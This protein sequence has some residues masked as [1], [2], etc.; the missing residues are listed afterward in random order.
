MTINWRKPVIGTLAAIITAITPTI[1]TFYH[2]HKFSVSGVYHIS[3][4]DDNW[5]IEYN[6]RRHLA[7][8]E[9]ARLHRGTTI[10]SYNREDPRYV[11]FMCLRGGDIIHE[12]QLGLTSPANW[13]A[14]KL[15]GMP[16]KE[17][18]FSITIDL[19]SIENRLF[20]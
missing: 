6:V 17:L 16:Q 5:A 4:P 14:E 8:N 2:N 19:S 9:S 15:L 20:K 7:G 1:P 3:Y 12:R 18:P 11:D 13:V 10:V